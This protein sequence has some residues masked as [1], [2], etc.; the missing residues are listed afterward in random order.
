M[1]AEPAT[2]VVAAPL[3]PAT[4]PAPPPDT[5]LTIPAYRL[6]LVAQVLVWASSAVFLMLPKSLAVDLHAGA[7]G[8]GLVMGALG[9]GAVLM[10]PFIGSLTGRLGRRHCLVLANLGMALGA[11]LFIAVEAVGPLAIVARALQGAAG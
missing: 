11:L 5:L 7:G 10:S 1:S 6:L 2:L 9:G 8:I 3:E 4:A